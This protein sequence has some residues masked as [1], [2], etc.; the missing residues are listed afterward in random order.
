MLFP[1]DLT[2]SALLDMSALIVTT[3][4]TRVSMAV[5]IL[6]LLLYPT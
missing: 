4:T 3:N 6:T 2:S 1:N 5:L